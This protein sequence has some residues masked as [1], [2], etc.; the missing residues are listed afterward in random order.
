VAEGYLFEFERRGYLKAGAYVPEVVLKHPDLVKS[1]HEEF[2][3]AGSDVVLAFT[4]SPD[5]RMMMMMMMMIMM[6]IIMMMMETT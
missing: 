3:H 1:L 5:A 6:M 4:V 2:V